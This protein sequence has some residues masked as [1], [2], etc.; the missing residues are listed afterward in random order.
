MSIISCCQHRETFYLSNKYKQNKHHPDCR[1][2]G[3][4][5]GKKN[6]SGNK[7]KLPKDDLAFLVETTNYTELEIKE[8]Y[9]SFLKECPAGV[10]RKVDLHNMYLKILPKE[11]PA[12]IVDHLFRIF[13]RDNSGTI[14]FKEFVLA[15]DI[16]SSGEP[17]EKLRWTFRLYD[18]DCSGTIEMSEMVEVLET[19]YVMEGLMSGNMARERAKQ[20]F[21]EL[22]ID[23]DGTLTCD[24]FVNGCLK[25]KDM[26]AML[27]Q[28]NTP[29]TTDQ[30]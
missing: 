8:W 21:D 15:T 9:R 18:K 26:V 6:S 27:K 22:D 14:D 1:A 3:H 2:M 28:S 10:L 24:E 5:D 13:D 17:E 20:I 4:P 19:V 11:D 29:P 25:D 23:G 7:V 30:E 12:V 16:T